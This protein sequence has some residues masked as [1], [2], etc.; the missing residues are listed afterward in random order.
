M[1]ELVVAIMMA[2]RLVISRP[3]GTNVKPSVLQDYKDQVV[4][5]SQSISAAASDKLTEDFFNNFKKL[6]K[7]LIYTNEKDTGIKK[8]LDCDGDEDK[9]LLNGELGNKENIMFQVMNVF[10]KQGTEYDKQ[11]GKLN[12]S[13]AKY[14]GLNGKHM[15]DPLL[16]EAK[17][18]KLI[19][20]HPS[21]EIC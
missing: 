21:R 7:L 20:I 8:F 18:Q 16:I 3:I 9:Y 11:V 17:K 14:V 4:A 19:S 10:E 5:L 13:D 2:K 6:V 1:S 15:T 12:C